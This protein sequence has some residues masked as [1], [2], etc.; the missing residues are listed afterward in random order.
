MKQ[1][2][3]Y[4]AQI[5]KELT[6]QSPAV[7]ACITDHHEDWTGGGYPL[8]KRK[9]AIHVFGRII[10]CCDVFSA[11]TSD[12][13]YR[14]GVSTA[15]TKDEMYEMQE[16]EKCFD[17]VLFEKF[18]DMIPRYP[19]GVDVVLANGDG[20]TVVDHRDGDPERPLIRIDGEEGTIVEGNSR[21]SL[22]I[23]N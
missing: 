8:G 4:G 14:I 6:V 7:Q 16:G 13:S 22:E 17:P 23:V 19:I 18:M 1:H 20:G 21:P 9:E 11:I 5:M 3:V 10:R 15:R 12:R 2:T